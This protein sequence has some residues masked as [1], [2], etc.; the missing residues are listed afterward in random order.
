MALK[1]TML[2]VFGC[3]V[4][5]LGAGCSSSTEDE[6]ALLKSENTELRGQ[7]DDRDKALEAANDEL[8]RANRDLRDQQEAFAT[9]RDTWTATSADAFEG[10]E[11]VEAT[12]GPNDVTVTVEGDVLFA[13]G[14]ASL[15]S[16]AKQALDRVAKVLRSDFGGKSIVI[17]GHTDSDPIK[18]SG[19]QSNH[20]LGFERG[21][22]VRDY[23]ASKGVDEDTMAII[24]YGPDRPRGSA[25]K[26][27]RVEIVVAD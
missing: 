3:G 1:R 26:S 6:L 21:W 9:E 18:K 20:H 5:A 12:Y 17:A 4:L 25:T 8:R 14:K 11:G 7:L 22:A 13:S 27:R 16:A 15:R 24:S 23:L 2:M 19:H 10:I